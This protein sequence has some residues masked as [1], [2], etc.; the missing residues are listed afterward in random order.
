MVVYV[1]YS[2]ELIELSLNEEVEPD[3]K[4]IEPN[5]KDIEAKD[6][7]EEEHDPYEQL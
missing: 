1:P 5:E 2:P 6:E 4:E 7:E 3:N